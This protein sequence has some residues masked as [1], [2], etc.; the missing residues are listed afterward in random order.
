M[1]IFLQ[2]LGMNIMTTGENKL[3]II[4]H[5]PIFLHD[6]TH[7]FS[8]IPLFHHSSVPNEGVHINFVRSLQDIA[9]GDFTVNYVHGS[10]ASRL[11]HASP[12]T[13]ALFKTSQTV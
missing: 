8:P 3:Q 5:L 7:L 12:G 6:V 2:Y 13:A 10:K 1:V 11:V 4:F 9:D